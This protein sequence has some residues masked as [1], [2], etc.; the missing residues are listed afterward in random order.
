MLKRNYQIVKLVQ[1]IAK[2]ISEK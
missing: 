1:T 2:T